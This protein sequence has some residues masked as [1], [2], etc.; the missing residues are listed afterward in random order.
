MRF[1]TLIRW[2]KEGRKSFDIR[3]LIILDEDVP[4]EADRYRKDRTRPVL[5]FEESGSF[6]HEQEQANKRTKS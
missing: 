5:S 6:C 3:A 1:Q 4:E 2:E